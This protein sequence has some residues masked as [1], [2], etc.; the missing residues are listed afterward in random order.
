MFGDDKIGF[1]VNLTESFWAL[2]FAKDFAMDSA[3]L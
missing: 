3:N 1:I 2:E